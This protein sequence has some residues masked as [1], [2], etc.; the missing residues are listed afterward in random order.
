MKVDMWTANIG[1]GLSSLPT[2]TAD[3]YL[4]TWLNLIDWK[5]AVLNFSLYPREIHWKKIHMNYMKP[6]LKKIGPC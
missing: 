2:V 4:E 5:L 6:I 3:P 1:G